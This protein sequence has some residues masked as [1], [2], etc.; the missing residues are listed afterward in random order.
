LSLAIVPF[1]GSE[2]V[3]QLEEGSIMY[4]ATLAP[5]AGLDEGIRTATELEHI[6][7]R[8]P[9]VVDVVSKIGRAEA[10][11]DPEPV[12]GA[13][14]VQVEQVTGAAC[15]PAIPMAILTSAAA[16]AGASLIPSPTM[17]TR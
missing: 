5:S 17:P 4:R 10:G 12:A 2:F 9:E 7:K 15:V 14:D 11:G 8:I 3:L 16:S 13:A 6:T 1:L